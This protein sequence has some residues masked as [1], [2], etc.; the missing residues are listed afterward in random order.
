M[1]G[2]STVVKSR[3]GKEYAVVLM[4]YLTNW[5]EMFAVKNQD[6]FTM[7]YVLVLP[8]LL[9]IRSSFEIFINLALYFYLIYKLAKSTSLKTR[10]V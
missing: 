4:D 7:F 10:Q 6:T 1:Y 8:S 2:N 3:K 5:L 9:L